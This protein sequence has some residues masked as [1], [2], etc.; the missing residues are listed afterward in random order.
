MALQ[1]CIRNGGEA[2]VKLITPALKTIPEDAIDARVRTEI[3]NSNTYT[4]RLWFLIVLLYVLEIEINFP[5]DPYA[6]YM[7]LHGYKYIHATFFL[8]GDVFRY[9]CILETR[10]QEHHDMVRPTAR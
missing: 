10:M 9:M 7:I 8:V 3:I 6:N 4:G 5:D 2:W 1:D